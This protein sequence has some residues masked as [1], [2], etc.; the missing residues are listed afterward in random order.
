MIGKKAPQNWVGADHCWMMGPRSEKAM[1]TNHCCNFRNRR[2]EFNATYSITKPVYA[3]FKHFRKNS[4]SLLF[5]DHID[6]NSLGQFYG[7][8]SAEH[9]VSDGTAVVSGNEAAI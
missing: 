8:R 1:A 6:D 2:S 3:K 4:D 9:N 7:L 5:S